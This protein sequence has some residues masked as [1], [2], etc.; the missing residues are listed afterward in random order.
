MSKKTNQKVGKFERIWGQS[1]KSRVPFLFVLV[2]FL[3]DK[4]ISGLAVAVGVSRQAVHGW[5]VGADPSASNIIAAAEYLDVPIEAMTSIQGLC[6]YVSKLKAE[7]DKMQK[8]INNLNEQI[9]KQF[10]CY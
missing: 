8:S 9:C 4:S 10:G 1:E 2:E 3:K 5:K 7:D 6:N